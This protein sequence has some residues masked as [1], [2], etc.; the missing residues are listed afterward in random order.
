MKRLVA[1][2][3]GRVSYEEGLRLQLETWEQR[4]RDNICDTLLLL[5]HDSVFTMGRRDSQHN[6]LLPAAM[7]GAPVVQSSRGGEMTYHGPGQ[8]VAYLHAK[9]GELD[10]GRGPDDGGQNRGIGVKELIYRLEESIILLLR[11]RYGLAPWRDLQHRGV[12]LGDDNGRA[13]ACS[14]RKIAALGISVQRGV[15]MHGFAL[16]ISTDLSFFERIIPC[17]IAGRGVT[18]L[19][20]ELLGLEYWRG[21]LEANSAPLAL[22]RIAGQLLKYFRLA[23]GYNQ[24]DSI[25]AE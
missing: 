8:L 21:E 7:L 1:K 18:S 24:V 14:A 20:Q 12:W 4:V 10:D 2:Y 16:N 23:F 13:Q 9:L 11:G 15:S 17:G 19:E 5:E 22:P 6:M 3:L 25:L